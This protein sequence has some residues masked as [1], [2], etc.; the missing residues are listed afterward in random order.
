MSI[1]KQLFST[2][3][4]RIS[5]IVYSIPLNCNVEVRSISRSKSDPEHNS[6]VAFEGSYYSGP[7][8]NVQIK[9]INIFPKIIIKICKENNISM[10]MFTTE[11]M[12]V[13]QDNIFRDVIPTHNVV[14]ATLER[15]ANNYAK[16]II[17]K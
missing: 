4:T 5:N 14:D 10:S 17:G 6:P 3:Y 16:A 13:I 11:L 8:A 1:F 9:K 15:V 2:N 7:K 12:M